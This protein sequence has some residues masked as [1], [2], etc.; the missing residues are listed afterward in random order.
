M[1]NLKNR[2]VVITGS[3]SGLGKQMAYA[4]A[5]QGA[6]LV[7]LARRIEKLNELSQEI[8]ALGVDALAIKCDV[9]KPN[10][11]EESAKKVKEYY[12]KVDILVNCAGS[13]KNNGVLNMTDEE[14]NFTIDTDL[15]SVFYVTRAYANIMKENNYGRIINIASMYGMV[16]N[17]A[18]ETVAYH[19][20]KG[21]VINFT[22]AVAAELA[23]YN[24]TCNA[25]CPGYFETELTRDTLNTK[26]FTDY[27]K[28]TVPLGRY[29]KEGELNA[30]AIFLASDEASYVTGVI[31]PIDGG[32]TAV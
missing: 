21:G 13:A 30:G 9:T 14:W 25:I 6:N 11:I 28:L 4:F 20:S 22:R 16:G 26:E 18:L 1:F 24:I 31:L 7:L 32:Y 27:M 2:V 8:K 29:G 15:N 5:K 10:E 19:S 17:T 12:G 23:K 3:S